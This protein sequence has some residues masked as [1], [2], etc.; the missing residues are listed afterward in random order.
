MRPLKERGKREQ[1]PEELKELMERRQGRGEIPSFRNIVAGE[2]SG[3]GIPG[4][5]KENNR[6]APVLG[7]R[8][9]ASTGNIC[10]PRA[11]K[12]PRYVIPNNKLEDYRCYMRD[13]ALI[14]KF[15]GF[16]PSEKDLTKWV[17]Q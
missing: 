17:Q 14:C 4:S 2:A 5:Q 7:N 16:W 1:K 15:V 12:K 6:E 3:N 9:Q 8:W 13:H 10:L 11:Q